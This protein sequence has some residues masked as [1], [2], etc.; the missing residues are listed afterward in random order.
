MAKKGGKNK[1]R[2]S[3]P[4]SSTGTST[5]NPP[6]PPPEPADQLDPLELDSSSASTPANASDVETE[7]E[8]EGEFHEA[9]STVDVAALVEAVHESVQAQMPQQPPSPA[10][11]D[12]DDNPHSSSSSSSTPPSSNSSKMPVPADMLEERD[13]SSTPRAEAFSSPPLHPADLPVEDDDSAL[14]TVPALDRELHI[15]VSPSPDTPP[16][17]DLALTSPETPQSSNSFTDRNATP[18]ETPSQYTSVVQHYSSGSNLHRA[19]GGPE[20][21]NSIASAVWRSTAGNGGGMVD[22]DLGSASPK[23]AKGKQKKRESG[24]TRIIEWNPRYQ[25]EEDDVDEEGDE[26]GELGESTRLRRSASDGALDSPGSDRDNPLNFDPKAS[27]PSIAG[28]A[29]DSNTRIRESF[30]RIRTEKK[31]R[32]SSDSD[33]KVDWDFW[34]AVMNDY[35]SVA[36]SQPKELSRAIQQGIPQALRG[37]TWQLMAAS[38]DIALEATYSSLLKQPSIHEK[39]IGRDLSRTFPKHEYFVEGG[40]GQQNL[41]NVVKAYSLYDEEVGYTQGLQ[42]I[43]GPLLLNMPDE[44]AFCV[45][46]R[47][48]K[49]YDL[50]SHYTPNMPG[51]QL[52]LFQFDRLLEELLPAVFMHLLRQGVKSS[53]YASQ[54]FLTLFGYRFPLELVSS[55]F[56]LVFAEGV[57]AIFRFALAILKNNEQRILELEFEELIEYLKNGLFEAYAPDFDDPRDDPPYRADEFVREALQVRITPVMLDQFSE[58]WE[59][60]C[61]QQNAHTAEI[62]NLRRVN[63][64]LSAQVRQ[65]E[66]SLAQINQEHCELVKQVVEGRLEREELEDELVKC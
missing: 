47:L 58:E 63:A 42:F 16:H 59:N 28:A 31:L 60:L 29:H 45:L 61:A 13:A 65:L 43:V 50:R 25:K 35:E 27:R 55:V 21:D 36:A 14:A 66:V 32:G 11:S 48:M 56:D 12:Q 33:D 18:P 39:S 54:W 52:R 64:Q 10:L 51:L 23:G 3:K 7:T 19:S 1:G 40:A 5:S 8:T 38:K 57:E 46:V 34:G 15:E 53:M 37:M 24:V 26:V 6:T 17:S 49:S 44:E 62:E 30:A 9:A 22:V 41:F 20:E 4:R 2:P